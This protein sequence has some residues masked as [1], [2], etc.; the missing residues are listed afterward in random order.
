MSIK[1]GVIDDMDNRY[2]ISSIIDYP[3]Q[4]LDR[5]IWDDDYVL[6]CKLEDIILV[7]LDDYMQLCNFDYSM[8]MCAYEENV[9]IY[10]NQIIIVGSSGSYNWTDSSDIDVHIIMDEDTKQKFITVLHENIKKVNGMLWNKHPINY[11]FMTEYN[12]SEVDNAY[13]VL[14]RE[15]VKFP[16]RKPFEEG[17]EKDYTNIFDMAKE[18]ASRI[19][20]SLGELKR[21]G[22]DFISLINA[23]KIATE[24]DK[25][26]LVFLLEDKEKEIQ[27]DID[28]LVKDF[29]IIHKKRLEGF[30]KDLENNGLEVLN[31]PSK[32]YLPSNILW[33]IIEHW[34]YVEILRSLKDMNKDNEVTEEEIK[35]MLED[36]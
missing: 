18:W 19:D 33:K 29:D 5:T 35:E 2:I 24:E 27:N 30:V 23:L 15:W 10:I 32:N 31:I 25:E 36:I 11:Y 13:D 14:Y 26:K 8:S 21:D 17:F 4:D 9:D 7:L 3:R 22:E 1:K 28:I 16:I 34:R 6:N 12:L 20:L